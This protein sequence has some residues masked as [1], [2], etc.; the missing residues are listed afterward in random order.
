[1]AKERKKATT[2]GQITSRAKIKTARPSGMISPKKKGLRRLLVVVLIH[3][4]PVEH[5]LSRVLQT[6]IKGLQTAG[7][8]AGRTIPSY[9]YLRSA[10]GMDAG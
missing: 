6:P 7:S 9:D 10:H 4:A 3:P 5:I 8:K 1:M 2:K